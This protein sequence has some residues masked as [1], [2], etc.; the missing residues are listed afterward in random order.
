MASGCCPASAASMS[1]ESF[2]CRVLAASMGNESFKEEPAPGLRRMSGGEAEGRTEVEVGDTP[3]IEVESVR[4]SEEEGS[5]SRSAR[6]DCDRL[7][8]EWLGDR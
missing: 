4:V 6:G 8:S 7:R 1:N 5:V 3:A 2:G